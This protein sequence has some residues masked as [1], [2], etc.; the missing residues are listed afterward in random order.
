MFILSLSR[1]RPSLTGP[2][3]CAR[4]E[5]GIM[6]ELTQSFH[7]DLVLNDMAATSKP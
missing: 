3:V 7:V 4:E 2:A 6:A 1:V 5:C